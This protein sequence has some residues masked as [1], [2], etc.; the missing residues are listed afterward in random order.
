MQTTSKIFTMLFC[1]VQQ[2]K[3]D[4]ITVNV[5]KPWKQPMAENNNAFKAIG[6]RKMR[7]IAFRLCI[8]CL[9]YGRSYA[10]MLQFFI[11]IRGIGNYH[12][13]QRNE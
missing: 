11:N 8:L 10:G 4:S 7:E 6:Q 12:E 9:V 1:S 2:A 5:S 13:S 3:P